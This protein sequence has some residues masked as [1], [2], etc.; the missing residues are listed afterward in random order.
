MLDW[1]ADDERDLLRTCLLSTVTDVV[2]KAVDGQA[3][4]KPYLTWGEWENAMT[5][6]EAGLSMKT[7]VEFRTIL[8]GLPAGFARDLFTYRVANNLRDRAAR[9]A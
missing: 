9:K 7:L 1:R 4:T 5:E 8:M 3:L 2:A 6:V